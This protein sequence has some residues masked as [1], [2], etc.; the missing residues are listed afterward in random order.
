MFKK[1]TELDFFYYWFLNC[2]FNLSIDHD[3]LTNRNWIEFRNYGV[4]YLNSGYEKYVSRLECRLREA[5]HKPI[6]FLGETK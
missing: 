2:S 4:F 6:Y 3:D 5:S 1:V